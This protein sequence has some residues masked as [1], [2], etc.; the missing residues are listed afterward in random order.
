[1][2]REEWRR[3]GR[4]VD[5]YIVDDKTGLKMEGY[6]NSEGGERGAKRE[7]QRPGKSVDFVIIRHK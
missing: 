1:M 6:F 3:A 4:G 7:L 5:T 2:E